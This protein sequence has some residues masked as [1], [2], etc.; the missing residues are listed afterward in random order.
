MDATKTCASC[1]YFSGVANQCRIRAPNVI[2]IY[3]G[4]ELHGFNGFWP[5]TQANNWCGEWHAEDLLMRN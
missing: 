5:P 4:T 1:K 3:N 2:P